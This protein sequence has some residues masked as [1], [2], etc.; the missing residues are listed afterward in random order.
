MTQACD[1]AQRKTNRVVVAWVRTAREIVDAKLL[2]ADQVRNQVRT[3][4]MLGW[5]FLPGAPDP[6]RMPEAIVEMRELHTIPLAILEG[7]AITG[8]RACRIKSPWREH[9]AQ[10][11]A[12]TYMRIGLPEP[13]STEA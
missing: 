11:F 4:R 8:R 3:H 5:Y 1:L 12:V 2:S 9:L 6:I 7:L 10:H 13:Y